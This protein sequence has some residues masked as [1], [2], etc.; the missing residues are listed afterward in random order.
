[1]TA[2]AP[3]RYKLHWSPK[4]PF[5]RKVMITAHE[6]EL[7]ERLELVRSVASM[8]GTNP[9]IMADN[10]LNKI[11]T[12]VCPDGTPIQDS[13]VI[14]AFLDDLAGGDHLFPPTGKRRWRS[15]SLHALSDGLLDLLI[16]WRNERD[17][18]PERQTAAWLQALEAKATATL[19]RCEQDVAAIATQP[20]CIGQIA[21][22][23]ALGYLDFRFPDP[24]WRKGRSGLSDWFAIFSKRPSAIA[25]EPADD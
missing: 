2:N 13:L 12:L 11:P 16:L 14:C 8:S 22:G 25:T 20:L 1:M 9:A 19:D 6:L 23:C 3:P 24:G 17:K 21:L 7:V 4:S 5:V 18:P 15:L 10:P